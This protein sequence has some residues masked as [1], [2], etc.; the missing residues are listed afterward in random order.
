MECLNCG[1]DTLF[2]SNVVIVEEELILDILE[3]Y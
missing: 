1:D 2:R 3:L